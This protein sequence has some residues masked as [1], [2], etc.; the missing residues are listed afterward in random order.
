MFA[1][2]HPVSIV[3]ILVLMDFRLKDSRK[4]RYI[5][6]GID[7]SILV[8]MDFRLK[9]WAGFRRTISVACFNPCSNGLSA[10][11]EGM[12]KGGPG[13]TAFQSLF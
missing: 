10:Q 1:H 6:R 13:G 9:D 5:H 4:A 12:V 8:L 3:S 2:R 7:V 11:S